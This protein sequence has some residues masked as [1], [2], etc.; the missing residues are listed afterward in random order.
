MVE[1]H[2][3]NVPATK[4]VIM[5]I[6]SVLRTCTGETPPKKKTRLK[7]GIEAA[8]NN[9]TLTN[10]AINLPANRE[11]AESLEHNRR[12][13]VC[14][15]FSPLMAVAVKAGAINMIRKS[16]MNDKRAYSCAPIWLRR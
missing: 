12:S 9:N 14:R 2:K 11:N 8:I 10:P 13:K 5:K 16:C 3:L 6:I 4:A 7:S 1:Q 15:S